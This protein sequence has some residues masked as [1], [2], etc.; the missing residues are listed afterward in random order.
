MADAPAAIRQD[1]VVDI[2]SFGAIVVGV[3]AGWGVGVGLVAG[4][5]HAGVVSSW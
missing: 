1:H 3:G 2:I 5:V 4:V